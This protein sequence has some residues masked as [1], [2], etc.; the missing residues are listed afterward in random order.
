MK[1]YGHHLKNT[2]LG[3]L[4]GIP[5]GCAV[6]GLILIPLTLAVDPGQFEVVGA[7][8]WW[9]AM[10]SLLCIV[11]CIPVGLFFGAPVGAF[12]FRMAWANVWTAALAGCVPGFVAWVIY[13][14]VSQGV[15]PFLYGLPIAISTYWFAKRRLMWLQ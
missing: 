7:I 2:L 4:F 3:L 9:V 8:I 12:L 14:D 13:S 10:G 6:G 15:Y 1:S 5:T 11:F